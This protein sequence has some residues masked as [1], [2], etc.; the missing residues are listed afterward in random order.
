MNC[1][2]KQLRRKFILYQILSKLF[3]SINIYK[4]Y[5]LWI[6]EEPN[7]EEPNKDIG[8]DPTLEKLLLLL[9]FTKSFKHATIMIYSVLYS[10][11]LEEHNCLILTLKHV[12]KLRCRVRVLKID[13]K[14]TFHNITQ[15]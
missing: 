10:W 4:L 14:P 13:S 3:R 2:T 9:H 1:E 6:P 8:L 12:P 7:I 15:V 11:L 5:V